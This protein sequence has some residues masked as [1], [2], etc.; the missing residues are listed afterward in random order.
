MIVHWV[1][2]DIHRN[3]LPDDGRYF[4]RRARAQHKAQAGRL[5]V[6]NVAD[7]IGPRSAVENGDSPTERAD[8]RYSS[9]SHKS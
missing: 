2:L 6:F 4:W 3:L 5:D 1:E 7:P 9:I 8:A